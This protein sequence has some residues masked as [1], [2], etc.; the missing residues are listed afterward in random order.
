MVT[1]VDVSFPLELNRFLKISEDVFQSLMKNTRALS[2]SGEESHLL[3]QVREARTMSL[4]S[5]VIALTV[6]LTFFVKL[7]H[8]VFQ[9]ASKIET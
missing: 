6:G 8:F 3:L 1:R 4:I 7:L 5:L 2:A 9:I